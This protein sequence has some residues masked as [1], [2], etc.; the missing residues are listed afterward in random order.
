MRNTSLFILLVQC[1]VLLPACTDDRESGDHVWRTQTDTLE[2]A[3]NVEQIL[4]EAEQKRLK[5]DE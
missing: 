2:K 5:M 4:I 1:L 3:E